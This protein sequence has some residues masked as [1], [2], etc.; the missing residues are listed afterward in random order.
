MKNISILGS[1]WLGQPLAATLVQQG[2]QLN[3]STRSQ[4]KLNSLKSAN[5]D[6]FIVDIAKLDAQT[7][8]FLTADLL[9]I[10]I[11][12]KDI[13]A[14]EAL[15][16]QLEQ[17]TVKKVIF[18]S[19]SSVYLSNNQVVSEDQQHENSGSVLFQIEQLFQQN[20]HFS[21]TV[22]RLAGLIGPKRHPG[23]FFQNDKVIKHADN[24]VNLVHLDDCL[25]IISVVIKQ[26]QWGQVF[27][28]CADNHPTKREF[29]KY[30]SS[31]L[32][33]PLPQCSPLESGDYKIVSNLKVKNILGYTFIHPDIMK[34]EY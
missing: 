34:I 5:I 29:Y 27:N 18:V 23:R 12:S 2:Y 32:G 33:L 21:T 14:F 17:S 20:S 1:G 24:P 19:S 3:L 4:S 9:I 28:A 25:A 31:S 11:T 15:I 22:I 7:A 10:N 13:V 8:D 16:K 30:A 6:V 26:Q